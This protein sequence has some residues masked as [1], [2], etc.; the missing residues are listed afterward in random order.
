MNAAARGALEGV[1]IIDLTQ[2]LAGPFCT[3]ML[4]DQGA[5]VIKIEPLGGDYVRS[6]APFH[7]DDSERAFSGYFASVNRNKKSVA[8]DLKTA[9]GRELVIRLCRDADAVVENYRVGVMERLGLSFEVLRAGNPRLVYACVRG[10]RRPGD[11]AKPLRGV[12]GL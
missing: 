8:L 4:A 1:R 11:R 2:M 10:L 5:E 6:G 12:A 3:M 7:P 9:Q